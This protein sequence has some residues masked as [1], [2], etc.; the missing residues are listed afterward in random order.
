MTLSW[1]P[2]LS[3]RWTALGLFLFALT[4]HV[5][6]ALGGT[7]DFKFLIILDEI[8]AILLAPI[9]FAV[10]LGIS[11]RDAFVLRSARWGHYVMAV[12]TAI[13]LQLFGGAMQEIVLDLMPGGD[14]WRQLLED[15]LGPLLRGNTTGDLLVLMFGAVVL[16]AICEEVLFRGLLMQL[17]ARGGRWWFAIIVSALLFALFHLDFIGLLPRT[18]LG[19]YF[20]VLVWRS[21]S[22][23][24][25]MVA[26][27]A[28]NLL[29]FGLAPFA[30]ASA[31]PPSLIQTLLLAAAAGSVFM[32]M[33]TAY[34][35]FTKPQ[36][37]A[38]STSPAPGPTDTSPPPDSTPRT[39]P[40]ES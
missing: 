4:L 28:N 22:I 2:P 36:L 27:G 32:V 15:S 33:M 16:A 20:G 29:A 7:L 26:H 10:L 24:P 18:L 6:I 14:E 21:G 3:A 9:L 35:R 37:D 25:A 39:D 8:A 12:A 5:F 31:P 38:T 17:L 34:L 30:D 40:H 23:F 11:F 13:P 19:I 1:P